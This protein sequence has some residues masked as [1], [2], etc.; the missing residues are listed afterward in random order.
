MDLQYGGGNCVVLSS[1]GVR[2]VV[3]DNLAELGAKSVTKP[4]DI[5][6]S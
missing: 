4:E 3:D 5:V 2:L 6:Y 1:K